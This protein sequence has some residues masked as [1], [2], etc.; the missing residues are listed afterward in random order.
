MQLVLCFTSGK[1]LGLPYV[2]GRSASGDE[3]QL[4]PEEFGSRLR[5]YTV[6]PWQR[7]T[8]FAAARRWDGSSRVPAGARA[9]GLRPH[10][11]PS[12]CTRSAPTAAGRPP[13]QLPSP[14]SLQHSIAGFCLILCLQRLWLPRFFSASRRIRSFLLEKTYSFSQPSISGAEAGHA[15]G[16]VALRLWRVPRPP[17]GAGGGEA[18]RDRAA[19]SHTIFVCLEITLPEYFSKRADEVF[20][21]PSHPGEPLSHPPAQL[22][23]SESSWVSLTFF[24]S[25]KSVWKWKELP[26]QLVEASCHFQQLGSFPKAAEHHSWA[27]GRTQP[28]LQL[29]RQPSPAAEPPLLPASGHQALQAAGT[30][31]PQ[32]G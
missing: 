31:V 23:N 26:I 2:F 30:P 3:E 29:P 9:D 1:T 21:S 19:R 20:V 24:I 18:K 10:P 12:A 13:C 8:A 4:S 25:R 5:P 32:P 7:Q 28:F 27:G 6:S 11:L 22:L 15:A 16:A 17:R 14:C